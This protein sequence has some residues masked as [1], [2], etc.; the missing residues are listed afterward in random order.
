MSY[1]ESEST[2]ACFE[3]MLNNKPMQLDN[4]I[5]VIDLMAQLSLSERKLVIEINQCILP[6]S[7]WS[8]VTLKSGDI[9]EIIEAVGGG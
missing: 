5:N 3:I 9:V 1:H 4:A 6:R 2:Q 7:Q 8:E